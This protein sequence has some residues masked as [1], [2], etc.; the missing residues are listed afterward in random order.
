MLRANIS[1]FSK[2]EG[3]VSYGTECN[4][5]HVKSE[6]HSTFLELEVVLKKDCKLEQQLKESLKPEVMDGDNKYYC[7]NCSQL[8]TATRSTTLSHLPPVLHVSLLRFVFSAK[9]YTRSKSTHSMY[10]PLK[11]NMG[12]FLPSRE[13]DEDFGEKKE[14]WYDL[15]GVLMH[16]GT[17]AHHGHYVA[18]V[19][20]AR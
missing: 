9:D 20:D 1:L 10:Y 14:V 4:H 17:S 12:E 6:R 16:K 3:K 15:R 18:Q 5:C 8:R 11:L 13:D 19:R 7:D 2:F